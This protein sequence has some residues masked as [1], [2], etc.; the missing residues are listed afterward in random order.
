MESLKFGD[1]IRY[2]EKEYVFLAKTDELVYAAQIL[3]IETSTKIDNLYKGRLS[4]GKIQ[5]LNWK[6]YAYVMLYYTTKY[7]DRIAHFENSQ[8]D[9]PELIFEKL[10][11]L[12]L[13]DIKAIRDDIVMENSFVSL[14][15]KELVSKLD[16]E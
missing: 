1:V 5:K 4:D 7:K 13:G 14:E 12:E 2:K 15:L 8:H 9:A 6:L 3:D 11:T 10:G 16:I